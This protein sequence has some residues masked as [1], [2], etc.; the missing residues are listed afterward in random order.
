MMIALAF[1]WP[2][3][4]PVSLLLTACGRGR[5]VGSLDGVAGI[6]RRL[7]LLPAIAE[8]LGRRWSLPCG[9]GWLHPSSHVLFHG[10]RQAVPQP[11]WARGAAGCGCRVFVVGCWCHWCWGAA[12][13]RRPGDTCSPCCLLVCDAWSR[14]FD[15]RWCSLCDRFARLM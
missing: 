1:I 14:C 4:G 8:T 7:L 2:S 13:P 6:A 10:P 11:V 5:G 3:R 12:W 9:C 15:S